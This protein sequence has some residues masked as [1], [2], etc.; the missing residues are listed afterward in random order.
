M[1]LVNAM[2]LYA[3]YM[4]KNLL[5]TYGSFKIHVQHTIYDRFITFLKPYQ[6]LD[7]LENTL[8]TVA[9]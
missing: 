2:Y 6:R 3:Y 5:H 9:Q 7:C 4:Q 8:I 1:Q